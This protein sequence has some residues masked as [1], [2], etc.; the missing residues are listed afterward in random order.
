[1]SISRPRTRTLTKTTSTNPTGPEASKLATTKAERR[2]KVFTRKRGFA[3]LAVQI[4]VLSATVLV[5]T[6]LRFTGAQPF[7]APRPHLKTTPRQPVLQAG[8]PGIYRFTPGRVR[9]ELPDDFGWTMAHGT[10]GL[11]ATGNRSSGATSELWL[12]GCSL[13]HGWSVN[14]EE[15]YPWLLQSSLTNFAVINGGVSGYGTLHSRLLFQELLQQRAK[16][17]I[18][19]YAYG[20]FHDYRN[21]YI[22]LWQ[23]GFVPTNDRL[24]F[25]VPRARFGAGDEIVYDELPVDYH[26]WPLQRHSA[27]VHALEGRFNQWEAG[28]SRSHEISRQLVAQWAAF[29]LKENIRFIVAGI[30]SDADPMLTFCESLGIETVNIAVPLS[31]EEYT[32]LPH[33]NHPNAK[34]HR[35]YA[36][37]LLEHLQPAD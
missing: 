28:R 18:I 1:M 14:D 24:A 36:R 7:H 26:E 20:L 10:N 22:R 32:N 16:P 8:A 9:V 15:T 11:R 29:C 21:T 6:I 25:T 34:A 3:F 33:D 30:S 19:V 5:E 13:T 12:M 27:L 17:T 35:E 2:S 31:G 23:K 37:R 4:G